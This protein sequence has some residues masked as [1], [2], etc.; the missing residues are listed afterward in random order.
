MPNTLLINLQSAQQPII[1]QH[2]LQRF[3]IVS[4]LYFC[5]CISAM[6]I[7]EPLSI[8]NFIAPAA[9]LFSGLVIIWGSIAFIGI[10]CTT[11]FIAGFFYYGLELNPTVAIMSIALL[12]ITLQGVLTK[13]LAFRLVYQAKWL[14]SRR[15]LLIFLL[16][17]GP[18]ASLISATA[19]LIVSILD[20]QTIQGTFLY[21]FVSSWVTSMLFAVFFIPLLL[22]SK[23]KT[24]FNIRKRFFV[25]LTSILGA[26]AI[27]TLFI[28]SQNEQQSYRLD[29]FLQTKQEIT[30]D[31]VQEIDNVVMQVE[32][33]SALF[34]ASEHVE[35]DE[36]MLFSERIFSH[37][38]SVIALKWAPLVH[39]N[40]KTEFEHLASKELQKT[41]NIKEMPDTL[42]SNAPSLKS[43]YAPLLYIYPKSDAQLLGVDVYGMFQKSLLTSS[44][45]SGIF[46]SEPSLVE[47][48]N[49][50]K[51]SIFFS[52]AVPHL[53]PV[54]LNRYGNSKP[55]P[56]LLSQ[57]QGFV[58]AVVQFESFFDSLTKKYNPKISINIEDISGN[59][60]Y[61]IYGQGVSGINRHIDF[62]EISVHSRQW[63]ISISEY[64]PWLIQEM[65]AHT[66]YVLLG[67]AIGALLFQ[68]LVLIT[69]AYSSELNQQ[70][71]LKT[72]ALRLD[73]SKFEKRSIAKTYFLEAFNDEL[74]MPLQVIKTFVEQLKQRGINNKQVS[75]I[76]H[77]SNTIGQLLNTMAD[78]SE[79]ELGK[80]SVKH[81][82][83][84]LYGLLNRE[85]LI[86]KGEKLNEN[87][88]IYFLIDSEVPHFINSDEL[89]IQKL[90]GLLIKS[91][92]QLFGETPL[93]LAV[94]LHQHKMDSATLFFIFSNQGDVFTPYSRE[95]FNIATSK[96][97]GSYSTSMAIIKE[98]CQLLHGN[99]NVGFLASGDGVLSASVKVSITTLEQQKAHQAKYFDENR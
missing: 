17:I 29:K 34:Y 85:E 24:L 48:D 88:T 19:V 84:D 67:G 20:N 51:P 58:V 39:R 89:R 79:I 44:Q 99:V 98:V 33:M 11:P 74:R 1:M 57:M 76:Y 65:N 77:A 78:L 72:R 2:N 7:I 15:L 40:M 5:L 42:K 26:S 41:Y 38:D 23:E 6:L 73:K 27:F 32:S 21:T 71:E 3:F 93:R 83:F 66:W 53:T 4:L 92:Q 47:Q 55:Q 36:F 68:L 30:Q 94:K 52:T 61:L 82:T 9:A 87:K 56:A 96:D 45:A 60:P 86:L 31:I 64:K 62:S 54:A 75:G 50:A 69:V 13:Q 12:A 18:L 91:A 35:S 70:V 10:L 22:L 8:I 59:T 37:S 25:T 16:R 80:V 43:I 81:D 63:R 97:L 49:F 28:T 46:A 14:K 95:Q 90:L